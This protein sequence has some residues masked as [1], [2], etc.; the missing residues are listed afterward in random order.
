[1]SLVTVL[2]HPLVNDRLRT[3]RRRET[4][5]ESFRRALKGLG[6]FL[7]VE[8]TSQLPT[9][10]SPVV[11]PLG[12][13]AP[14]E[15]LDSSRL[16]LV[17]ILRAGLGFVE[18][19]L[20]L[21]PRARVA[22]IGIARDHETLEAKTYLSSLPAN[23]GDFDGVFVLD[24]MLATGNSCVK[25]L[26]ILVESGYAPEK[27]VLVCGF[28]VETGIK[29]VNERFPSIRI[30]TAVIDWKLNEVGYIVPGLGDAGDRLNLI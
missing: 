7:A 4:D 1:M 3:L 12:I 14:A 18:S 2:K 10:Q 6:F 8:A 19:F 29:Q 28:A 30:V 26:E 27:I 9:K 20:E 24:P 16:L 23:P 11:T 21:L 5:I 17:P 22:H 25:T 13:E 15:E